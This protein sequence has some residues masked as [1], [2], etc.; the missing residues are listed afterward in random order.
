[1]HMFSVKQK[2]FETPEEHLKELSELQKDGQMVEKLI[3][4]A[5]FE[6]SHE[7]LRT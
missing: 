5:L 4:K 7:V 3:E 2:S 1:M 6:T